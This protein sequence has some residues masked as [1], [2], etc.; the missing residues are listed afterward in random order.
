[1]SKRLTK[2]KSFSFHRSYFDVVNELESD[3]DKLDFLLAIL[4]KQFMNEDPK[5][6]SFIPNLCYESQRHSIET[7]VKGW[8]RATNEVLGLPQGS[9]PPTPQGS[10]PPTPKQEEEE[11]EEE[12]EK[13]KEEKRVFNFRK[14]LLDQ[15][16]SSKLVAD[17]LKVRKDGKASNTETAL[18]KFITQV[19]KSGKSLNDI[20]ELCC[21]KSW[22]G[23]D[24]SW[25][26][27]TNNLPKH[28][29]PDRKPTDNL[30]F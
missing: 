7:S 22:K 25:I 2:R 27:E 4:N 9:T 20:L 13:E 1:M 6:L 14:S 3:G 16:A 21:E 5:G 24:A 23:F 15:G 19:G 18:K 30:T 8:E 11:E 12:E 28:L 29:R 17:W 10:T 26:K